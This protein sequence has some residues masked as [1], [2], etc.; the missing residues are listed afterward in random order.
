MTDDK[1]PDESASHALI[2]S[3]SGLYSTMP[4]E[5]AF[6][7]GVEFGRLWDQ[8]RAGRDAEI[9][10]TVHAANRVV[11]ERAAISQG[12]AVEFKATDYPE[13]LY[14]QMTK[15][16]PERRNPHGLKIVQSI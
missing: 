1:V 12:W 8:M 3:F 10:Q 4:E 9:E 6:V 16:G 15:A 5:H 7:H 14:V 2:L 13:W 11:I